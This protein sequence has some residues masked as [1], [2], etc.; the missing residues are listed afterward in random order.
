MKIRLPGSRSH[1]AGRLGRSVVLWLAGP[2][3][4][5]ACGSAGSDGASSSPTAPDSGTSTSDAG[6][7][8]L[9]ESGSE[10]GPSSDAATNGNAPVSVAAGGSFSCVVLA[11]GSVACWGLGQTGQLGVDPS[12]LAGCGVGDGSTTA[13]RSAP[14]LVLGLS[15]VTRVVAES[16]GACAITTSGDLYCWGRNDHGELGHAAGSNGDGLCSAN[17]VSFACNWVPS[18]VAGIANVTA[19]AVGQWNVCA[20]SGGKVYCW[21][22][23]GFDANGQGAARGS[24]LHTPSLVAGLPSDITELAGSAVAN[25]VCAVST[26][27]GVY[28]WGRNDSGEL[29]HTS[30]GGTPS[31][32]SLNLPGGEGNGTPQLV[33]GTT[34]LHSLIAPSGATCAIGTSGVMCWGDNNLG[35]LGIGSITQQELTQ[36]TPTLNLVKGATSLVGPGSSPLCA[37]LSG[38]VLSCWGPA[39]T[40]ELGNGAFNGLG[41]PDGGITDCGSQLTGCAKSPQTVSGLTFKEASSGQEIQIAST[42]T[43]RQFGGHV[44]ALGT[45][46]KVYGWGAN[47]FGE[48]GHETGADDDQECTY[49][50]ATTGE[51][52]SC[53]PVPKVVVGLP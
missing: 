31:D 34:G 39:Q 26:A 41:S 24:D 8:S 48:A 20:L 9:T 35:E 17:S 50:T 5:L 11:S 32:D 47:V 22:Y 15:N 18:K 46:G 21:G 10:T 38:G 51:S 16:A 40:G 4:V 52:V 7:S 36:I 2:A 1:D 45:D 29:G 49:T 25:H 27:S 3:L 6:P 12:T 43:G 30:G 23:D 42:G 53:A 14:A 37:I 19:V 33:P 28:C 44:V 13:C